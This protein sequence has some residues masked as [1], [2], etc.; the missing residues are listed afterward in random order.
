MWSVECSNFFFQKEF[1]T[2][3][4]K[5]LCQGDCLISLLKGCQRWLRFESSFWCWRGQGRQHCEPS[6]TA[7]A[8]SWGDTWAPQWNLESHSLQRNRGAGGGADERKEEKTRVKW[9]PKVDHI[10]IQ[11]ESEKLSLSPSWECSEDRSWLEAKIILILLCLINIWNL[12][13]SFCKA[14][15]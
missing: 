8:V 7:S 3:G 11:L 1:F 10:S 5:P 15:P 13:L 12:P 2:P 9:S 14:A 6:V 4:Q